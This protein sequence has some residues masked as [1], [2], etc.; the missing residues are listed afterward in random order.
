MAR[1]TSYKYFSAYDDSVPAECATLTVA[2]CSINSLVDAR[3]KIRSA[4][5]LLP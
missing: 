2:I 3:W 1:M 4:S 5:F